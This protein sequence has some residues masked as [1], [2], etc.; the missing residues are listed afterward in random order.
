MHP[1]T[2]NASRLLLPSRSI[3]K[4]IKPGSLEFILQVL[5]DIHA[6]IYDIYPLVAKIP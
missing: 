5:Q 6:A 4:L 2:P 3:N 1:K